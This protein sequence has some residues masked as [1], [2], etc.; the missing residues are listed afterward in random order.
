MY[1]IYILYSETSDKYYVG[2]SH[3][4]EQRFY[5]HNNSQRSTYTSKH[6]PWVIAAVFE[7]SDIEGEAVKMERWIKRQK[8]RSLIER[9]V[10]G[11]ELTG[12]LAQLTRITYVRN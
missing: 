7:C 6:R 12:K 9:M 5:Q 4:Y 11:N 1:Y 8:S 2:Y 10:Q 3:D